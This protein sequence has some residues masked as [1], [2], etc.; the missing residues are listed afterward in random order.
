MCYHYIYG[1]ETKHFRYQLRNKPY[2]MYRRWY[3]QSWVMGWDGDRVW[4]YM[5]LIKWDCIWVY[6]VFW[7]CSAIAIYFLVTIMFHKLL[8]NVGKILFVLW[9]M[10][11]GFLYEFI[12]SV[13]E[14]MC[15]WGLFPVTFSDRL[16]VIRIEYVYR[17]E[18]LKGNV[19]IFCVI[20]HVC[21]T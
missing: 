13:H 6:V 9:C 19:Y 1:N 21:Y 2:F 12:I 16:N 4:G 3:T 7:V 18:K 11:L 15:I 17:N 10:Q 14:K 5:N 20:L 8:N